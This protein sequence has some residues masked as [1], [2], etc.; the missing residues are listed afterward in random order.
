V[1][2]STD[3]RRLFDV[4]RPRLLDGHLNQRQVE[5]VEALVSGWKQRCGSRDPRWLAYVMATVHHE[6]ASTYQ[7][8]RETLAATDEAAISRLDRAFAAGRLRAVRTPYW[9]RDPDGLCWFGRG[10]VQITHRF[11]Y[12]RLGRLIGQPLN[13]HPDLALRPDIAMDILFQGMITGQFTGRRLADYFHD[14][15]E[16]W[17]GARRIINGQDRAETIAGYARIWLEALS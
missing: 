15:T 12:E 6:T 8:V 1:P 16:D 5:G 17:I 13:Q 14:Q 3:H 11:N 4:L 9:R 7:P 2:H 10:Y